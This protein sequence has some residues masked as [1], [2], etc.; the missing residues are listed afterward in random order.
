MQKLFIEQDVTEIYL[1]MWFPIN[2]SLKLPFWIIRKA[3]QATALVVFFT[4]MQSK[5]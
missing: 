1:V 4:G 3:A 2:N 5:R